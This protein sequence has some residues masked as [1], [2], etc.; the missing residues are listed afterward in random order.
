MK[1]A[2][3][4][5]FNQP[6]VIEDIK[7]DPPKVGE[8]KVR[9]VA[10]AICHSDVH[11]IKGEWGGVPP[12]VAG[13]EGAGIVEEIG[14][15][16]N[17]VQKGDHVVV[18][19]LRSCG[20]CEPCTTGAPHLCDGEF[21]LQNESRLHNRQGQSIRH[22]LNTAAF[23]EY[24]IVDQSQL[25]PVPKEMQFESAA[26]LAC[27]VITGLGAVINRARVGPG[28]SVVVIGAGG[29]GLNSIQ[30]AHLVGAHPIIAID[31][32]DNKLK[33]AYTFGATHALNATKEDIQT[34]VSEITGG[35]LADYVFVTGGTTSATEQAYS[36]TRKRGMVVLVGIP[37]WI[38]A[39]PVPIGPTVLT[40]KIIT[41]SLMGTTRLSV[42]IPW[43]VALYKENRLKLDELITARY[44]LDQI[45]DALVAMQSGSVLRN[46]I[47]FD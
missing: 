9:M 45:N 14:S 26:L 47:L 34:A 2:V 3:C 16:V 25:A 43:L 31:L 17:L 36:M 18:S 11:V 42:D 12:V 20:R 39:M 38:S 30:G 4:Y 24:V 46:V 8:V 7:I 23:A 37:D 35:R 6:L 44:S 1:A 21:A 27:G 28:S 33:T 5:Q 32:L 13:H 22:G 41:G 10:T 15:G 19:L 29:V 40:E